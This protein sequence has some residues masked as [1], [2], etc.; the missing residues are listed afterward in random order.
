[1]PKRINDTGLRRQRILKSAR[2]VFLEK[3][4]HGATIDD[5]AIEEGVVR[6]TILHYYKSKK[7]LME[8]VLEDNDREWEPLMTELINR[9]EIDVREIGRAHV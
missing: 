3:G 5:I 6:G 2:K 1:M 4:F 9:R 7:L 8:A